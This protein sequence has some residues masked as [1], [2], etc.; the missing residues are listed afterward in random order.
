MLDFVYDLFFIML[1][2]SSFD[3]LV[4]DTVGLYVEGMKSFERRWLLQ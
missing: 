1:K 3:I 4:I 2:Q